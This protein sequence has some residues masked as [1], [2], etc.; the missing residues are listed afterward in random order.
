MSIIELIHSCIC[1]KESNCTDC[2]YNGYDKCEEKLFE[3]ILN[4]LEKR[5]EQMS[6]CE[7]CLFQRQED[8]TK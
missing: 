1:C 6:K 4:E 7:V 3:D 8:K 2:N 5:E